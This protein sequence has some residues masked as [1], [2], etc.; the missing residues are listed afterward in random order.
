MAGMDVFNQNAFT[1]V[2]MTEAFVESEYLPQELSGD[3]ETRSVSTEKVAIEKKGSVLTLIPT[4]E[5]G[6][7]V[8]EK[9]GEKRDIR[10]F[11]TVRLAKGST[12]YASE[13]ANIRAFGSMTEAA[14]IETLVADRVKDLDDDLELSFEKCRL[15]AIQGKM[16]DPATEEV[17]YDWFTEFGVTKPAIVD[18]DLDNASPAQGAL[19][20]KCNAMVRA[21]IQESKGAVTPQTRIKAKVGSKFWDD[22]TSHPEVEKTYL[23]WQAAQDLRGDLQKPFGQEFKFGNIYWSE[24]RGTD[25]NSK[26]TIEADKA[27]F[28]PVGVKGNLV[29]TMSPSD[30]FMEYV[31]TPGQRKY[32]LMEEDPAVNKKW[33]RPE[34]YAYPLFYVSRP[35]TLR[36]G[37]A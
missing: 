24:Y 15:G 36:S 26:V 32:V 29:H 23:N 12:I 9:T 1:L 14:Q 13:V 22:L 11:R 7:P 30:E 10:D 19:M 34:I 3:F 18:F 27:Y 28:Y 20:K 21:I 8:D 37:K 6:S 25:D 2:E 16:I 35:L 4:S 33:V 17:I 31:N 5:R